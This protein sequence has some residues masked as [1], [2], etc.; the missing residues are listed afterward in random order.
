MP[1]T[2]LELYDRLMT[3]E[4][5]DIRNEVATLCGIMSGIEGRVEKMRRGFVPLSDLED[6]KERAREAGSRHQMFAFALD[7]IGKMVGVAIDQEEGWTHEDIDRLEAAVSAALR[8]AGI[9]DAGGITAGRLAGAW[10]RMEGDPAHADKDPIDRAGVVLG[11][12]RHKPAATVETPT[13]QPYGY[14]VTK[15]RPGAS[16]T[17][18]KAIADGMV[19]A[20][21]G[22][23]L[24]T[25]YTAPMPPQ[26]FAPAKRSRPS[27][28][29]CLIAN[30]DDID[31]RTVDCPHQTLTVLVALASPDFIQRRFHVRC[32]IGSSDGPAFAR[33]RCGP[34]G[35]LQL[36]WSDSPTREPCSWELL[37]WTADLIAAEQ[38]SFVP[39]PP[40]DA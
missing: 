11:Q 38:V 9:A 1:P 30:R 15:A 8:D 20:R 3:M 10:A 16:F 26:P 14:V 33:I 13:Q 31:H 4:G 12:L 22:A 39:A 18:S 21:D 7:G 36:A 34:S 27:C 29:N 6:W 19:K 32:L 24:V 17:T 25:V 28:T 40:E 23:E 5:T 35:V 2:L 37:D